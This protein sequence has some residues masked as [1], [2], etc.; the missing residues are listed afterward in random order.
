MT[1]KKFLFSIFYFT[2]AL[3]VYVLISLKLHL[4]WISPILDAPSHIMGGIVTAMMLAYF[5]FT[6]FPRIQGANLNITIF[7][8][9]LVVGILWEVFELRFYMT[10]L[11]N[12]GYF[13]ETISDIISNL[14]GSLIAQYYF[15]KKLYVR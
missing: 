4:Y 15:I 13:T 9:V 6:F 1:R 10:S 7:L 2:L 12:Y 8:G 14:T 11:S 3:F 5:L